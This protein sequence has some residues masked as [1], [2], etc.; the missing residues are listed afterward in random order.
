MAV[1]KVSR[2]MPTRSMVPVETCEVSTVVIL[3]SVEPPGV[4]VTG[5]LAN[6]HAPQEI[7]HLGGA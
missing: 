4:H 6:R 2:M 3:Y 5:P 7:C 1:A